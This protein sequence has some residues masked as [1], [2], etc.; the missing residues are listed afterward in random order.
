MKKNIALKEEVVA[1]LST[2]VD[3]LQ[4]QVVDLQTTVQ[5]NQDTIIAK[6]NTI[7]ERRKELATVFY[8][9]GTKKDLEGQGV[10]VTK[11]GVLGVGKT[12]ALSGTYNSG[13]FTALDTD[14]QTLIETPA[15]KVDKV[16]VISAQPTSSYEL[17]MAPDN[18]IQIHIIDPVEFR[19]VKHLVVVTG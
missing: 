13:A 6:D 2:R 9:V 17:T 14:Q 4:T 10:L 3:S 19:K 8:V 18:K 11:G 16:K 7:E 1:S 15:L 5:A 12:M